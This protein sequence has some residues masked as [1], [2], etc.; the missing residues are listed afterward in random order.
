MHGQSMREKRRERKAE[1]AKTAKISGGGEAGGE[2]SLGTEEKV[3]HTRHCAKEETEKMNNTY[4]RS[5]VVL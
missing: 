3:N 5:Q 4:Q 1:G 2:T